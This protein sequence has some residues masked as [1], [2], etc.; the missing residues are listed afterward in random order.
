M[1]EKLAEYAVREHPVRS[2]FTTKRIK[3]QIELDAQGRFLGAIELGNAGD[4]KNLGYEFRGVPEFPQNEMQSGGKAHPLVESLNV[5]ALLGKTPGDPISDKDRAKHDYFVRLL[6]ELGETLPEATTAA[7]TLADEEAIER[8]RRALEALKAKSSDKAT[9]AVAGR[10]LLE[11]PRAAEWW[12][13]RRAGGG[14]EGGSALC[15]VTGEPTEPLATHPK[16]SGLGAVG[17]LAIGSS[18]ISFDKGAFTSYGLDQSANAAVSEEAAMRYRAGLNEI[19]GNGKKLGPVIVGHWYSGSVP[20]EDDPLDRLFEGEADE[21]NRIDA[22][23]RAQKLLS[24]FE[25]GESSGLGDYRYYVLSLSGAA[26]RVMLRDWDEGRFEDL[27]RAVDQWFKDL[28]IVTPGGGLIRPPKFLAVAASTVREIDDLEAPAL[29]ALWHSARHCSKIPR[30]ARNGA[31]HRTRIDILDNQIRPI[32]MGLL[33]AYAIRNLA[34]ETLMKPYLNPEH[35]AKAYQAGRLMA[36]LANLQYAALGDVNSNVV[37]R[38]YPAASA[39]PALVFGRL[40]RQSHFHLGKLK[41]GKARYFERRIADI[42]G[43]ICNNL[44]NTFSLQDQTLFALGYYQQLAYDMA[45]KN[46]GETTD[47][48]TDEASE[49]QEQP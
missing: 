16:I 36:V 48:E 31:L 13:L 4:R 18:L 44:P 46:E 25:T 1:L 30:A 6:E 17:G 14:G 9:V 43:R 37:Q 21:M 40:V 7:R 23:V 29:T 34:Q 8:M 38:F 15:L 19:V 3:W 11:D 27:A 28:S 12:T 32:R 5:V 33:K 39:T 35:P 2:G 20:A 22:K 42:W 45:G 47:Q 49:I 41:P 10:R 26:G 24:A